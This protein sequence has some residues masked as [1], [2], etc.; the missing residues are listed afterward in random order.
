V[1]Y[2]SPLEG[3]T[4][5]VRIYKQIEAKINKCKT[6]HCWYILSRNATAKRWSATPRCRQAE[7]FP[8]ARDREVPEDENA[9][10]TL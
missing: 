3:N 1:Q 8:A 5:F 9:T 2:F 7:Y 6:N 10:T 4:A